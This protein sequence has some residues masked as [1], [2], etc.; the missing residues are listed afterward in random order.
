MDSKIYFEDICLSSALAPNEGRYDMDVL[1]ARIADTDSLVQSLHLQSQEIEE[2][3]TQLISLNDSAVKVNASF[4]EEQR[5]TIRLQ[6]ELN[7]AMAK[8]TMLEKKANELSN[9]QINQASYHKQVVADLENQ[10]SQHESEMIG[11]CKQFLVQGNVLAD[12]HL[13]DG[14]MN[15]TYMKVVEMLKRK[16]ESVDGLLKTTSSKRKRS[17]T[18][19]AATMTSSDSCSVFTMTETKKTSSSSCMTDDLP[20]LHTITTPAKSFCDRATQ[21]LPTTTTR[22]TTTSVFIQKV[23]IGTNFPEPVALKEIFRQTIIDIPAP[24][25]PILDFHW[26]TADSSCQTT[27][28][29]DNNIFVITNQP[30]PLSLQVHSVGTMTQLSNVRKTIDYTRDINR[31]LVLNGRH[32]PLGAIYDIKKEDSSPSGS[33]QNLSNAPPPVHPILGSQ[34]PIS[35][36][37]SGLWRILGQTIFSI[38]GTGRIFDNSPST[39]EMINA[40][41]EQIRS[42]VESGQ[43]LND[44]P[45]RLI[46]LETTLEANEDE[47]EREKNDF[48]DELESRLECDIGATETESERNMVADEEDNEMMENFVEGKHFLL[49]SFCAIF[50]LLFSK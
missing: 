14:A 46:E 22:G 2:L 26:P 12:N 5:K 31:R 50:V 11:L 18:C 25:S 42:V 24:I 43:E 20:A 47:V 9:E 45:P 8:S 32:H 49:F 48:A 23:S 36:H 10:Q 34:S 7:E 17:K 3:K 19:N 35:P 38:I 37:L 13:S 16:G 30:K 6:R 40:N 4:I 27:Q 28:S 44:E 41:L 39:M 15:R 1:A 21:H 33:M 29:E